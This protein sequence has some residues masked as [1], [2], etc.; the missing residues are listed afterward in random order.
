MQP[1]EPKRAASVSTSRPAN[2][3]VRGH[4]RA[5]TLSASSSA[6]PRAASTSSRNGPF[7]ST[8]RPGTRHPSS[9]LKRP[10]SSLESR[11]KVGPATTR[12]ATSLDTHAEEHTG[13]ESKRG[14]GRRHS[15]LYS[16]FFFHPWHF[17]GRYGDSFRNSVGLETA[18][19]GGVAQDPAGEDLALCTTLHNLTLTA[20][21]TRNMVAK[22]PVT[23][24]EGPRKPSPSKI[25]TPTPRRQVRSRRL[26]VS[27]KHS[28]QSHTLLPYLCKDSSVR[29][30]NYSTGNEWDIDNRSKALEEVVQVFYSRL[31]Q[32]GESSYV[33]KE[34][35][36]MYK[37]QGGLI[38][39]SLWC[40]ILTCTI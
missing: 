31:N 35:V 34:A 3:T 2:G 12:P 9:G 32:A 36:D 6:Y 19:L 38:S 37:S 26:S 1:P 29:A 14:N 27:P 18:L 33:L 22:P 24:Q 8:V 20:T 23:Y 40:G 39:W 21:P 28:S 25:P 15:H 10:H 4:G 16:P 17:S 5:N 30:F 7:S 13:N 11:K